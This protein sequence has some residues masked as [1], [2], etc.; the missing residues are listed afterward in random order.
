MP[1]N[2]GI[3]SPKHYGKVYQIN[4]VISKHNKDQRGQAHVNKTI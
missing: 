4:W 2:K 1:Q 3:Q